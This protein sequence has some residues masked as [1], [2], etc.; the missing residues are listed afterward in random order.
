MTPKEFK[1]WLKTCPSPNYH[2]V[3]VDGGLWKVNFW[4]EEISQF[5]GFRS[6][7]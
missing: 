3:E 7:S 5:E 1:D 6:S 4:V 2:V